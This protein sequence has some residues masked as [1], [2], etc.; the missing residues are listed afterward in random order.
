[1]ETIFES[2]GMKR[3]TAFNEVVLPDAVPPTKR[4]LLLFSIASQK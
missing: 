2:G 1:M 3:A 4:R